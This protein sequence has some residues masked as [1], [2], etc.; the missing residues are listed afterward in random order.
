VQ[1]FFGIS[2][3]ATTLFSVVSCDSPDDASS[4]AVLTTEALSANVAGL[5]CQPVTILE[6]AHRV[7]ARVVTD[8]VRIDDDAAGVAAPALRSFRMTAQYFGD[9]NVVSSRAITQVQCFS[10]Q[11]FRTK[12]T[13][14]LNGALTDATL[15]ADPLGVYDCT[16]PSPTQVFDVGSGESCEVRNYSEAVSLSCQ[17][18]SAIVT[19]NGEVVVTVNADNLRRDVLSRTQA[20]RRLVGDENVVANFR[21][22][23]VIN[24]DQQAAM[25]G[26]QAFNELAEQI[27]LASE[28]GQQI[29]DIG[30]F[31]R[32]L[33][34]PPEN[35]DFYAQLMKTQQI[36]QERLELL[37]EITSGAPLSPQQVNAFYRNFIEKSRLVD[38]LDVEN[39]ASARHQAT[40]LINET[41]DQLASANR[42]SPTYEQVKAGAEAM[43]EAHTSEGVFDPE[44]T[45]DFAVPDLQRSLTDED[46]EKRMVA[47]EMLHK[48][49]ELMLRDD[50]V[51]RAKDVLP[52]IQQIV[53]SMQNDAMDRVW[54]LYDVV[55]ATE[56][57]FDN[58]DPAGT[59]Y[60]VHITPEASAL[61]NIE[62]EPNSAV[63]YE[64][65][66]LLNEVAEYNRETGRVTVNYQAVIIINARQALDA[67]DLKR[68]LYHTETSYGVLNFLQT[69]GPAFLS[70]ALS[71]L[72]NT[73]TGVF[74]TAAD[75]V[76]DPE[77]F[78][79][80]LK[81]A[82]VNWRQTMDIILEQGL[83]VIHRWPNMTVEEKSRLLGQL[84]TQIL[85]SLPAK[86]RTA[87]NI[88]DIIRDASRLH[89]ENAARGLQLIEG[90]RVLLAPDAAIEVVKR[91]DYYELRNADDAVRILDSLDDVLPCS[92]VRSA[93]I[94]LHL[95]LATKPPCGPGGVGEAFEAF[96]ARAARM[97]VTNRDELRALMASSENLG[98]PGKVV[99]TLHF[100]PQEVS[101]AN[102][103][104]ARNGGVVVGP[105]SRSRAAIDG[106]YAGH[107]LQ[108]KTATGSLRTVLDMYGKAE[109]KVIKY[110][111]SDA[112]MYVQCEHLSRSDLLRDLTADRIPAR[113]IDGYITSV[114]YLTRD[115]WIDIVRGVV[116]VP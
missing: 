99:G 61:F 42:G 59:S 64:V 67:N 40:S 96:E 18:S 95:S 101:F 69:A 33:P 50:G 114:H 19:R 31:L 11:A 20:L 39:S 54:R 115:G 16:L 68:A 23:I 17:D 10:S 105:L 34:Q 104:V 37:A 63:A 27:R 83:D 86:A 51:Q 82:I 81:S 53:I 36:M 26:N 58:D 74:Y 72:G 3:L 6:V 1:R 5:T 103:I 28:A 106:F 66:N 46:V 52:P 48:I 41:I 45:I 62:V 12:A 108:L 97:G 65:I 85:L 87:S 92:I 70:G 47:A 88:D 111:F 24:P 93:T 49:N 90:G 30:D 25:I 38:R 21:F 91:L 13:S 43:L 29:P 56:Y 60:D 2:L 89:L 9:A 57:F 107:P 79:E 22:D 112:T 7:G 110:K 78:V 76:R 4:V 116:H 32:W 73:V 84:S 80:N 98:V 14:R 44:R 94:V 77:A 8:R 71:E 15:C 55:A 109:A 113:T 35:A 100:E 102:T 75:F